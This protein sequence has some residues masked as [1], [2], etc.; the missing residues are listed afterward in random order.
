M[1]V[2]LFGLQEYL[3]ND[4]ELATA[5]RSS[6]HKE[7]LRKE[8]SNGQNLKILQGLIFK[9]KRFCWPKIG[10]V[11]YPSLNPHGCMHVGEKI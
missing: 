3:H 1:E 9:N 4:R 7:K 2:F 10:C 6:L 5:T 11:L 8:G